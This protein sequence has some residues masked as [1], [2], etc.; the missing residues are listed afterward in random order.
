MKL[1]IVADTPEKIVE[2][3]REYPQLFVIS[4]SFKYQGYSKSFI[5][6]L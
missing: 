1:Q 3:G 5:N 2:G 6:F 4:L